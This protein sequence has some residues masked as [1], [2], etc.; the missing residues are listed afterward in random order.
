MDAAV[1]MVPFGVSDLERAGIPYTDTEKRG[2]VFRS[3]NEM[4]TTVKSVSWKSEGENAG[5]VYLDGLALVE[6]KF[7]GLDS[8]SAGTPGRRPARSPSTSASGSARSKRN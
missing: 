7:K 2:D 4:P 8:W 3:R 1:E 6:V 5:P